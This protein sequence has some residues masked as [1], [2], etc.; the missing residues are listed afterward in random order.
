[1][2]DFDPVS[3]MKEYRQFRRGRREVRGDGSSEGDVSTAFHIALIVLSVAALAVGDI[4]LK[5]ASLAGDFARAVGSSWMA[6]AVVLNLYQMAFVTY[7]FVAGWR[8]SI[9]GM[10]Q[11]VLYAVIILG[12]GVLY[13]K[14]PLTLA[15]SL[16]MGLAFAGVVLMNVEA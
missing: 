11:A 3:C 5:K 7:V 15:Q 6:F 2:S 10:L 8:L 4:F 1:M 14:E 12:A 16:G 13:F 9:V